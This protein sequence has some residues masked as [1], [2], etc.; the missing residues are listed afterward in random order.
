MAG[1]ELLMAISYQGTLKTGESYGPTEDPP[2]VA[3][4]YQ[5][6][7]STNGDR[8]HNPGSKTVTLTIK[9]APAV[10]I[11]PEAL[12]VRKGHSTHTNNVGHWLKHNEK[13][14]VWDVW[15]GEDEVWVQHDNSGG[16]G[17]GW[18]AME[19]EGKTFVEFVAKVGQE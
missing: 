7:V 17:I 6:T 16:H 19:Y 4:E 15:R 2:T 14:E 12:E 13:I 11:A 9:P 1:E 8:N 18:S 5:L 3:G 10:V